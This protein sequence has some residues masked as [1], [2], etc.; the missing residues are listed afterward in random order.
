MTL[1]NTNIRGM[2]LELKKKYTAEDVLAE[3][4]E[5]GCRAARDSR[6]SIHIV[7]N[8]LAGRGHD[9]NIESVLLDWF[10]FE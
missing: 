9:S 3:L 5:R 4:E 7:R 8:V 1:E 10:G 2:Y 6:Y